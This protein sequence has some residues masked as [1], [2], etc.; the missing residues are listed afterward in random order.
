MNWLSRKIGFSY[1]FAATNS[2]RATLLYFLQCPSL[3]GLKREL[4]K[5][6][7]KLRARIGLALRF[8]D[9]FNIS[10]ERFYIF[11]YFLKDVFIDIAGIRFSSLFCQFY[12]L[13]QYFKIVF[14]ICNHY[15]KPPI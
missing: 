7:K 4:T 11:I 12:F 15:T 6:A 2:F 10:T 8:V 3:F 9:R 5:E 1:T 13:E 14:L